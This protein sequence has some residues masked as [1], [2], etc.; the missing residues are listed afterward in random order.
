MKQPNL[1]KLKKF[2][3]SKY[4]TAKTSVDTNG[5]YFVS[6]ECG[7]LMKEYFIPNQTKV[8][9]AWHAVYDIIKIDQNIQRSHPDRMTLKL[10]ES[11][12]FRITKRMLGKRI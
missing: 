2:V 11:K 9:P 3:K 6:D 10:D 4:P 5:K 12:S 1:E 8:F 7:K